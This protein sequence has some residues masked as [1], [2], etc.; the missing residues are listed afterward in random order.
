MLS[1]LHGEDP[2]TN[3]VRLPFQDPG[4]RLVDLKVFATQCQQENEHTTKITSWSPQNLLN[5]R[6]FDSETLSLQIEF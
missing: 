4:R 2:P 1:G 5:C 3:G 6:Y